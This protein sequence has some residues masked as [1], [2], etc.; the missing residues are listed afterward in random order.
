MA[1][2]Y[3]VSWVALEVAGGGSAMARCSWAALEV[4]HAGTATARVSWNAME[5]AHAGVAAARVSWVALEVAS[6]YIP[7]RPGTQQNDLERLRHPLRRRPPQYE[8][9]PLGGMTPVPAVSGNDD[10]SIRRLTPRNRAPQSE[11][12]AP[13]TMPASAIYNNDDRGRRLKR[14]PTQ[15]FLNLAALIRGIRPILFTVT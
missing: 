8:L 3:R 1:N 9:P 10:L 4:A 14:M 11:A 2:E 15:S 12:Q 6:Q 5:V 13:Q 7:Q